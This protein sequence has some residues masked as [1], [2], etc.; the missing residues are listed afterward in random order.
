MQA[1]R[2]MTTGSGWKQSL[3]QA[4]D[5]TGSPRP[6]HLS[7]PRAGKAAAWATQAIL[8]AIHSGQLRTE[9][10]EDCE[11][12]AAKAAQ[13][14]AEAYAEIAPGPTERQVEDWNIHNDHVDGLTADYDLDREA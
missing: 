1:E 10:L 12:W 8:D 7:D 14:Q 13:Q 5:M 11:F 2:S 9:L 6:Q 4:A 3:R